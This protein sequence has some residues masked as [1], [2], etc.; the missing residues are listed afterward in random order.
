MRR[1]SSGGEESR[2]RRG[3]GDRARL[4]SGRPARPRGQGFGSR[5]RRP[6]VERR[7]RAPHDA[8]GAL[9]SVPTLP[10]PGRQA[11]RIAC[12]STGHHAGPPTIS[13]LDAPEL[14]ALTR[15]LLPRSPHETASPKRRALRQAQA[16]ESCAQGPIAGAKP[17]PIG[18]TRPTSE[19]DSK[20]PWLKPQ[21]PLGTVGAAAVSRRSGNELT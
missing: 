21:V 17:Q 7:R 9:G 18:L 13:P 16:F 11:H 2:P 15:V 4:G 6:G 10:S 20:R 3:L 19:R 8:P 14:P 5:S 1:P 12:I